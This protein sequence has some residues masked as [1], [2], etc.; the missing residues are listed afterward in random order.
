MA[1]ILIVDDRASN[2]QFLTTLLGRGGHRLLE[3]ANGA[4]ALDLV[5]AERPH[6]VIT[7]I[8]MP[9]MD[10]YEFVQHLRSDPELA[11]T[12]VIFLT[13]TYRAREARMVAQSCGVE[14]VLSK[15]CELQAILAAVD[16]ALG[17]EVSASDSAAAAKQAVAEADVLRQIDHPGSRYI[18]DLQAVRL[19]FDEVIDHSAKLIAQRDLARGLSKQLATN[20]GSLQ[21]VMARLSALIEVGMEMESERDPAKLVQLLFAAACDIIHSMYAAVGV[22][23]EKELTLR[24]V[25]TKG[26]EPRIF[27]TGDDRR[28]GLLGSLLSGRRAIRARSLD[29]EA[30][31]EGLPAGHP[32][33]LNILAVPIHSADRVYG[34]IYFADKTGAAEFSVE[35]ERLANIMATKLALLYENLGFYDVIQRHAAKLQIEAVERKRAQ[36]AASVSRA[37]LEG[38]IDSAMDAIISVDARQQIV[39][40]NAAA[41]RMF[42]RRYA[43]VIGQPLDLLLPERFRAAHRRHLDEFG[44]TGVSIRGV[45]AG[46]LSGLRADGTE[47]PVEATISQVDIAGTKLFTVIVRD[48]TERKQA[49]EKLRASEARFRSLTEVS[50]DWYFEL[51]GELS[52]HYTSQGRGQ[53]SGIPAERVLG[54]RL[55]DTN[56]TPLNFTWEQYR[57][58]LAA[59]KP[60]RDIEYLRIGEDGN[61]YYL[62]LS[63]EPVFDEAGAFIGYRG[64][65]RNITFRKQAE[66][67]LRESELRFRQMAENIREVFFL[68]DAANMQMLYVNPAYEEIWGRSA[69]SLYENPRSWTESIHPDDRAS[70]IAN[71]ERMQIT[72]RL[73]DE[74]RILRGDGTL[75]RIHV[76]AYPIRDDAGE[77]YRIAGI[78]EDITDSKEAEVKVRALNRVYAVLSGINALIVRVSDRDELFK[79]ACRIAVEAGHFRTSWIGLVDRNAM[80][81]VP[82]ASAGATPEHMTFIK[83]QISL[84]T[85]KPI[86]DTLVARAVR[87]KKAF[88]S[89]DTQNDP[90]VRFGKEHAERGTRSVAVLP[91]LVADEAVGVLALYTEEAGSFDEEELKLLTELAGDIAFAVDHIEK[92]EK[93]NY[94]AFYDPLTGLPNRTLFHDRLSHSLHARG[95]EAPF[96]AVVLLDLERF[97]HVNE[98]LGRQA[99]DELLR[100]VGE[101]LLRTNDTAARVGID[102]F[103]FT[104][105]G[106]RTAAEVNRAV[107]AVA[108]ACF[109]GPFLLNGGELNAACRI[110]VALHPAD[111][112]DADTLLRNAEAALRRSKRSGDRIVFYASEMNARVAEALAME[113]KLRRALERQ[114][115]VLHYQP[116]VNLADR[117][118]TGVEALIRWQDPDEKGL[119]PPDRFIP[120]LEET[121][122][123]VEV[124]LWVIG[125][126][127]TDFG[128]WAAKG[129]AVTRVAVNVSAIQLQREDF[130]DRVTY[131]V[132]RSGDAAARLELEITESLLMRDVEASKRKLSILRGLGI[133][134]SM[135]DFGTG[136]SSLSYMARLPVDTVKIDRSFVNG[137]VGNAEDASIVGG[138]IALVHSLG[139]EVIAEGVE[140]SEQAQRLAVLGCDEAQGYH[141]SRPVPAAQVEALMRSGGMLPAVPSA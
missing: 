123:I 89:N 136:Y 78:A 88:F 9:N 21:R 109:A 105:R 54:R 128:V 33:V 68:M 127:L 74:Y 51:D 50:S 14:I 17:V 63:G 61:R 126:A 25:Y 116:K 75:R 91:L 120:I 85:D 119:V 106:A 96:I 44:S 118:V 4:D 46:A 11:A 122:L 24:H 124:G 32:P 111:G 2:R 3:A 129:L 62:A 101:R 65:G 110:G 40:F 28:T 125:R 57:A 1:T 112:A 36:E 97:R 77:I 141:Y 58:D 30:G 6:L 107:D 8:L 139:K 83:N 86:G 103:A 69:A 99:G 98:T 59:R 67:A 53:L 20:V 31:A 135:D 7:D 5:R 60:F 92:A 41:E 131:A 22:L 82:V 18:K 56:V 114:E 84:A 93:L 48:V 34:W 13:A 66:E 42:G 94:L 100:G 104:L 121:G 47:F 76:R 10:G 26:I 49:E 102:I 37:R 35:D 52:I 138:I 108:M 137:M 113:N 70:A 132:Q 87:E 72:G 130:V 140:T 80:R 71:L 73:D 90:A 38:I 12:P 43:D 117:R 27:Q 55:W 64:V 95:G 29:T 134:V 16:K 15:P 133:H 19:D 23:D 81:I 115:F 39:L 79:G 45:Q